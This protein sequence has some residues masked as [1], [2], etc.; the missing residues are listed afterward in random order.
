MGARAY[1]LFLPWIVFVMVDRSTGLGIVWAS[2]AALV[3][4]SVLVGYAL[5]N[6]VSTL[7]PAGTLLALGAVLL[8]H[9]LVS[10]PTAEVL[11]P[12]GRA[13]FS[14]AIAGIL[15]ISLLLEPASE[16]GTRCVTP[17]ALWDSVEFHDLNRR[18]TCRWATTMLLLSLCFAIGGEWT[19][20]V[21]RT[22]CDWLLPLAAGVITCNRDAQTWSLWS[23]AHIHAEPR[24]L[25]MFAMVGPWMD[26]VDESESLA[27]IH[28]LR[29]SRQ[30]GT[31]LDPA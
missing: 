14:A 27:A 7:V 18:L 28:E 31:D 3:I 26:G 8:V 20:P 17:L 4:T 9:Y 13:L 10:V 24:S 30:D 12:F 21:V 23:D 2:V 25:D 11:D 1:A 22:A 6:R 5:F 29:S 16:Q 15:A 19:G